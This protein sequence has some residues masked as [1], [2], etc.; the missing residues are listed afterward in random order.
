AQLLY[1]PPASEQARRVAVAL[2][3]LDRALDEVLHV[4][5]A[6]EVRVDVLLRLLAWDLE[7]LRE[8]ERGDPVDDAEVDHLRHRALR[9]RQLRRLDAEHLDRGRRVDVL[10]AL[11]GLAELRLA[12]DVGEDAQL[13]LR[14]VRREQLVP[15]LRDEGGA[16]L[17]AEL[18]A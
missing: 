12:G 4:R 17:A 11:E 9:R 16:D 6:R 8:A 10:A 5:E 18:G 1:R 2:R 15:G 14:V 7:V 13:D 3:L